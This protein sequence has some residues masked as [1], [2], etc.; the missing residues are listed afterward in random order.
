MTLCIILTD[1][2]ENYASCDVQTAYWTG[3][4]DVHLTAVLV[5]QETLWCAVLV[6]QLKTDFRA[7]S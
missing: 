3:D 1:S 6:V 4:A 7:K 5:L 2:Y